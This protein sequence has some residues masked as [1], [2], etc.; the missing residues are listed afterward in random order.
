MF[1]K[2]YLL[3][4]LK[5]F[6]FQVK[7]DYYLNMDD[8]IQLKFKIKEFIYLWVIKSN[9]YR[10]IMPLKSFLLMHYRLFFPN[11]NNILSFLVRIQLKYCIYFIQHCQVIIQILFYI[12]RPFQLLLFTSD[13]QNDQ[14]I[15]KFKEV[16]YQGENQN[17]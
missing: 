15:L 16:N 13:L 4:F 7:V 6:Q 14:K 3:I 9:F 10:L 11:N 1:L 8:H 5:Q 17:F 2:Y 12:Y